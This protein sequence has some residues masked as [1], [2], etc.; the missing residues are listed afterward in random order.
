MA[1]KKKMKENETM[2]QFHTVNSLYA[3]G[4]AAYDL[5]EQLYKIEQD[6]QKSDLLLRQAAGAY[7]VLLQ[8]LLLGEDKACVFLAYL[9]GEGLVGNKANFDHQ[10]LFV[11][12]GKELGNESAA[13]K[14]L[15]DYKDG[16]EAYY[17]DLKPEV[18]KWIEV[19]KEH[20]VAKDQPITDKMIDSAFNDLTGKFSHSDGQK[21]VSDDIRHEVVLVG[22]DDHDTD[23]CCCTLL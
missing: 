22:N 5:M 13:D 19:I 3:D 7:K 9:C 17:E 21:Y 4:I 8:S 12:I 2:A 1:K 6:H 15:L 16:Y 18:K 10:R 20:K 11:L 14:M 23:S